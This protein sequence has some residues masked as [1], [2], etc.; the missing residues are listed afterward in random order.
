MKLPTAILFLFLGAIVPISCFVKYVEFDQNCGGFL[1]QAADANTVELAKERIDIAVDYIEKH[2]LT[3]GYTSVLW[4]TEDENV[5]YWYN[6]IKACQRELEQCKNASQLEKSNV[7]LKVRESL[8][9]NGKDGT[10]L[11]L[12]DGISLY[13]DNAYLG[14]L[15]AF[16]YVLILIGVLIFYDWLEEW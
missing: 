16:S 7:L 11:T 9:D 8:T 12:P 4:K 14:L 1:K 2:D 3:Y 5:E 10:E 6:N 15:R 13:P